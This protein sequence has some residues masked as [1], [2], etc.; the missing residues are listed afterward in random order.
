MKLI[1][2]RCGETRPAAVVREL[3]AAELPGVE[4]SDVKVEN[5]VV[6]VVCEDRDLG[7]VDAAFGRLWP[8]LA[9]LA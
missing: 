4:L 2:D 8:R 1:V 6:A 3:L 9:P 7:A 5:G